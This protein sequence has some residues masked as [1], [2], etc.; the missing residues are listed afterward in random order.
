MCAIVSTANVVDIVGQYNTY[1]SEYN[2]NYHYERTIRDDD[3]YE[4]TNIERPVRLCGAFEATG[5]PI[6]LH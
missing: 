3:E 4:Y 1:S 2:I 5:I 6:C